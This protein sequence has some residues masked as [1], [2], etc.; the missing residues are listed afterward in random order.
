MTPSTTPSSLIS[1]SVAARFLAVLQ[2]LL[3]STVLGAAASIKAT[4]L[5][6]EYLSEP[7]GLDVLQP[8]LSWQLEATRD[9]ARGQRQTAYQVLVATTE[10]ALRG[11]QADLWD[12]GWVSSSDS[13]NIVYRGKPL[14]SGQDCYWKVRVR[15]ERDAVSS[16]SK[17]AHW[18]MGLLQ[19]TDWKAKWIGTDQVF[20]K[21]QGWPPPDNTVPDPWFRKTFDLPKVPA[22]A[23][24]YVAAIGYHEIFVNGKRVGD[25]VLQP[26]ATDH[27]HRARYVTYDI[28]RHLKPGRNAL[29]LWLGV[30]WSIFPHYR[31]DDKPA[32]PIVL[33]QADI[34]VEP[35]VRIQVVTDETWKTHPSPNT[36]L[37]IWDFMHYGGEWYDARREVPDWS[38]ASA[39]ETAWKP[40]SLFKPKL[41]ISAEKT[42]PNRLVREIRPVAIQEPTNGVYRVDMGVNFAGWFELQV[43]GQPGDRIDLQFSER[44]SEPMTHRLHSTFIVRPSG[45]GTFRNRF[46]Y[47]VGRWV[48]IQ[49]LKQKP[50]LNQMRGWLVRTDYAR[51][52]HFECDQPLLNRIYDTALWTF[53][54][55]SL[56]AYVVDCPQRE[57]MGYGGDAHATTRMALDNYRLG[58]FYTKWIEDWRD[59]QGA[60][61]N[62]PYTSPT[63]WG[64]GGPGW[65]GYCITLP[66]E[67]YRHYGDVR[68]LQENFPMMQ[69]WLAFLETKSRDNMLVRWG[70]EW[71]FL[72]D[73]LWPGAEG[74]NG[75]TRET[76]FFNNCYWIFNLQTAA[77]IAEAIGAKDQ[78]AQYRQRADT[79]RSAVHQTFFQAADHSYV[80]GFP[81]YLAIALLVDLPPADLRA[82]V[83]KRLEQEI[84]VNR[85]GHIHA[86]ITGGAFLFKLLLEHERHDLIYPMVSQETYPG[87]GDML[88]RGATTFYEDWEAKLSYLHSSYL[89]VGTWF[90]EG[91]GGI[92]QPQQNGFRQFV[93]SPWIDPRLGPR[94]VKSHYDSLYGRIRS[95]WSVQGRNVHL[96]ITVPPNTEALLQVKQLDPSSL[97]EKGKPLTPVSRQGTPAFRLE[98]GNYELDGVLL[99]GER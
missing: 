55:L 11:E 25:M 80:N 2:V 49:G 74:V 33:A 76:L 67:M 71:D 53:E 81:A 54:N 37:G 52:G 63:Y 39:D 4:H 66:W 20:V 75:D 70:G 14:P 60:D 38:E 19:E 40:V 84:L 6:C 86:G 16:W 7:L 30:S 12:S 92:L 22:R 31:T 41:A 73:W 94:Q 47:G 44:E 62:L 65:S 3:V 69:R 45:K 96:R 89:Y 83:W 85:K 32:S 35:N 78:A 93:L 10:R 87:W 5:Q 88:R 77:R 51:A 18:S 98:P 28:T 46:N 79:V 34:Q 42:E 1:S 26:A 9:R 90:T 43:T 56:G 58:A 17:S 29:G 15:D 36:L 91:L 13:V 97:K 99:S 61:G 8:R 95:E 21:G 82:G 72:G 48:Q 59:V 50:S 57:R 27:R 68:I 64:G 24:L 23:M